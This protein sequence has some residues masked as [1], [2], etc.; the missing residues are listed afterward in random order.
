MSESLR[1]T[2]LYDT[3]VALGGKMVPFAGYEMP[4]QYPTGIRE[5]HRAVREAAGLFDVTHMGEFILRGP[6]AL[7][8]IQKIAVNDASTIEV[9]QAQYSAMCLMD[10]GVI[11]DLLVYRYP[12]HWV[13]VVNASNRAKDFAWVSQ[14]AE[15]MDVEIEDRSD[16]IALLAIQGPKASGIV[17]RLT[18]T[19]L[20]DIGYYKFDIGHVA[21]VP[22]TISRTGYTGE[23]GFELY[24]SAGDAVTVWEALMESGAPDGLIP[25]GLGARDSLRLEMGYALYGNDLDGEHSPLESSLGWITKFAKDDF[26]ARDVLAKQKEAGL[27]RRL[28][29]FRLDA[30]GFP[31]PGYEIVVDGEVAG[32]VTSGTLSP[33]LG[34]GIGLGYVPLSHA[35]AGSEIAIRIRGKDVPATVER[36]PFYKDGSIRR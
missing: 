31:R 10:G 17:Q 20:D 24:V 35:K 11:D 4:V 13:L 29:G 12:D 19:N 2:P 23:D 32:T 3:H 1:R 5:E 28:V 33:S 27:Q 9:G 8:L 26:I 16:D 36:P 22:A 14:Q 21:G 25:A 6:D 18:E 34:V 30:K 15:G 7:S